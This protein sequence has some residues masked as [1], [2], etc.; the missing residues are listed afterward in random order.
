MP[1]SP[2]NTWAAIGYVS[3]I[4][5]LIALVLH[6]EKRTQLLRQVQDVRDRLVA[7]T[8]RGAT[9]YEV[10]VDLNNNT[11]IRF[12]TTIPLSVGDFVEASA[13]GTLV[14][15]N[16]LSGAKILGVVVAVHVEL[17]APRNVAVLK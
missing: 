12:K 8:R 5:G 16:L 4:G 3:L 14:P 1:W 2:E 6:L 10:E 13:D 15:G 11:R 7:A 17:P 9:T